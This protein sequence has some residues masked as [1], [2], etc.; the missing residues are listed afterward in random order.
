MYGL[1]RKARVS[2]NPWTEYIGG[3]RDYDPLC[4]ATSQS[5]YPFLW[6]GGMRRACLAVGESAMP[7]DDVQVLLI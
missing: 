2:R 5:R 7:T 6:V 4:H 1:H 3:P